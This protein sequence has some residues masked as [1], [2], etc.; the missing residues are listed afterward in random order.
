MPMHWR[1]SDPRE[2]KRKV[3]ARSDLR[4][5]MMEEGEEITL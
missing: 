2:F 5:V 1:S 4:V 3:E